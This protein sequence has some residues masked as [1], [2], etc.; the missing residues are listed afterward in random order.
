ML[1][2]CYQQACC[3]KSAWNYMSNGINNTRESLKT[4]FQGAGEC[5]VHRSCYYDSGTWT[6][7]HHTVGICLWLFLT[8][9]VHLFPPGKHIFGKH[10]FNSALPKKWWSGDGESGQGL[11]HLL[12][13]APKSGMIPD[14]TYD[15][16]NTAR[17]TPELRARNSPWAPY[18]APPNK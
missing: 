13:Y 14:I 9:E 8:T 17:G 5:L 15:S 11:R 2:G 10:G 4:S 18:G 3:L 16:P 1:S 6:F 7:L 12:W